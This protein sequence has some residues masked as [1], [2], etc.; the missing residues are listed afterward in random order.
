M[1]WPVWLCWNQK[2]CSSSPQHTSHK[3]CTQ[4]GTSKVLQ[5]QPFLPVRQKY[6]AAC[7]SDH[8]GTQGAGTNGGGG[9][10]TS[11]PTPHATHIGSPARARL[12]LKKGDCNASF[13]SKRLDHSNVNSCCSTHAPPSSCTT[14]WKARSTFA[15]NP[16]LRKR[17][18]ALVESPQ[19][20]CGTRISPRSISA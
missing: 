13:A 5:Q 6:H 17:L 15:S 1:P 16:P 10:L 9:L 12:P 19:H 2:R 20:A 11:Q 14:R 3:G 8:S 4:G 7:S 18:K